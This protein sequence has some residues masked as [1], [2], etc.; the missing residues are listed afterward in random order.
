MTTLQRLELPYTETARPYF[1][2]LA[3]EPGAIWFH[4]GNPARAGHRWEW[5]SAWPDTRY[6]MLANQQVQREHQGKTSV[7]DTH[8]FLGWLATQQPELA[9][10]NDLPFT[11]GLAGHLNYEAGHGL[12]GLTGRHPSPTCLASID[13]Y[14]WSLVIDH[15]QRRSFLCLSEHLSET[16][17]RRVIAW[18]ETH[19][20]HTPER[21]SEP[22]IAPLNWRSGMSREA[23]QQRFATLKNYILAGDIYQANLTRPW[24]ADIDTR[25]TDWAIYS[26]LI[27]RVQAPYAVFHRAA[28]HTLMSVS[29]ERFITVNQGRIIT[30]PIKGTR[31][32]GATPEADQ[33]LAQELE[34]SEKDRAENLMIVDLLRNDLSRN[35]RAGSVKVPELCKPVTFSNVHHLVSTITADLAAGATPLDL[36]RDAFPGGSI[37]GA[38]K[39]RAMEIIDELEVCA[40]GPYCGTAF[41]L[42]D[43]GAFDSNIL[44]RS[45]L[46]TPNQLMCS[47]GGG[48]V[49]DSLANDEYEE[50][51]TKVAHILNALGTVSGR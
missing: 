37:T 49:A 8:D 10:D 23:Y 42:S 27:D 40:R 41:W 34:L 50:S 16:L 26:Q 9:I 17:R 36:L 21:H 19:R 43:S 24:Y 6:K 30:Q 47:G 11:S 32:R 25:I 1:A 31:P 3:N 20:G 44:I 35:A 13:R 14:N 22:A 51:A 46:R 39:R 15:E 45:L 29:P 33:R 5:C 18:F 48:I 38:P 2:T 28:D 7:I 12:Q 4:S